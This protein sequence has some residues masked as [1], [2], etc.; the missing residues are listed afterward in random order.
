MKEVAAL[1]VGEIGDP[2][3]VE[4]L[5]TALGDEDYEV[6]STGAKALGKVRDNRA[7]QPLISMLKEKSE[8]VLWHAVQALE[9]ITGESYGEDIFRW[10]QLIQ[11]EKK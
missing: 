1:V 10:E 2:R 9:V 4:P 7:I 6:R 8:I 3:A 11:Q 5:I